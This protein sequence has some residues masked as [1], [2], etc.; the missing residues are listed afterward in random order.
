MLRITGAFAVVCLCGGGIAAQNPQVP[1]PTLLTRDGGRVSWYHG[2]KHDLIAFDAV[3]DNKNKNTEVFIMAPDGS[4]RRCVTCEAGTPKGFVGQPS[5]HPDG[6]QMVIQVESENSSHRYYNHMSWGFDSDLWLVSRDGRG[7]VKIWDTP[8]GHA[9]LHPHFSSDGRTLIWAERIPTGQKIRRLIV[10]ALAPGGEN[11][12]TGWQ[13]HLADFDARSRQL[14]NHRRIKPN[15]EGFYETHS[16]RDGRIVYSYSKGE[17][18]VDDI[19]AVSPTGNNPQNLTSSP[20][21]WEEHGAFSSRGDLAFLSSRVDPRLKFPDSRP[22]DLRTE[23]FVR[24]DG[25]IRQLTDMNRRKGKKIVVSDFDWDRDGRR[26]AF[27]VA[28]LDASVNPEI[29]LVTVR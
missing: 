28:V 23:I 20:T 19:F 2:D 16:L 25:K 10:R 1:E 29:W 21:T 4:G 24:Q 6:E 13:I 17:S 26:I 8:A 7:A 22:A 3:V 27:Q 11:Q 5:W 14:S 18:Y 15:G 12:W 9:A